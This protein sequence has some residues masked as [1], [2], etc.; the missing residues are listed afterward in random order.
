MATL[1]Y[2]ATDFQGAMLWFTKWGIWSPRDEGIGYR[3]I[4][5]MHAAAGQP[6]SLE[7]SP[8]HLFRADELDDAIGMLLQPMIFGWDAVFVPSW[9]YGHPEFFLH[10]SHDSYVTVV[11][12][13]QE[14][15]AKVFEDLQKLDLNPK[16]G[17]DLAVQRFCRISGT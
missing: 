11:T 17:H 15:H 12:R 13:T 16:P 8:G 1:G 7:T 14:F 10:V 2:E 3:I 9:S 5:A 6:G 4:E